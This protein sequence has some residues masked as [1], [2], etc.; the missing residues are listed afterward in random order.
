MNLFFLFICFGVYFFVCFAIG[1]SGFVDGFAGT[2]GCV[3]HAS[4][5]TLDIFAN[6]FNGIA[7]REAKSQ[8]NGKKG[9]KTHYLLLLL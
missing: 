6:T 9:K 5:N 8:H 3:R 1:L 4:T 7:S 2:L